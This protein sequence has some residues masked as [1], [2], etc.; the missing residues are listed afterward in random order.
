M[1][2]Q[3][4]GSNFWRW[5]YKVFCYFRVHERE[6]WKYNWDFRWTYAR[7]ELLSRRYSFSFWPSNVSRQSMNSIRNLKFEIRLFFAIFISPITRYVYFKSINGMKLDRSCQNGWVSSKQTVETEK[8]N[9]F[10][11]IGQ[12]EKPYRAV[13]SSSLCWKLKSWKINSMCQV[14]T[15]IG[16]DAIFIIF[17]SSK[18]VIFASVEMNRTSWKK[19]GK[20]EF[21]YFAYFHLTTWCEHQS[22][23]N[24]I[25][26]LRK[27]NENS[28]EFDKLFKCF[29]RAIP[30]SLFFFCSCNFYLVFCWLK[31]ACQ[32]NI[33]GAQQWRHILHRKFAHNFSA[34]DE[35]SFDSQRH[36]AH[37]LF[38][39]FFFFFGGCKWHQIACRKYDSTFECTKQSQ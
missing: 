37:I 32:Q 19:W 23:E 28:P 21:I 24:V 13:C 5:A 3:K 8:L 18:C 34:N 11:R 36:Q 2:L 12:M 20:K 27:P 39:I 22:L 25:R 17:C 29:Y 31:I 10:F 14:A 35:F 6:Y 33:M 38:V 16:S 26:I 30:L 9:E 7:I 1:F 15:T 4:N